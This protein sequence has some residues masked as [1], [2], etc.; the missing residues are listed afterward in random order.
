M[1][2]ERKSLREVEASLWN[3]FEDFVIQLD[4]NDMRF[5]G[6]GLTAGK[7]IMQIRFA[8]WI[9]VRYIERFVNIKET[10]KLKFG[11]EQQCGGHKPSSGP[12]AGETY[13]SSK[14]NRNVC[15]FRK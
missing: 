7:T 10:E 4:N 12:A 13:Q 5:P 1:R 14:F 6:P 2:A 15:V 11:V 3:G 9:L 8:Y